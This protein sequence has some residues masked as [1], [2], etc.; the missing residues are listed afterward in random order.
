MVPDLRVVGDAPI[1]DIAGASRSHTFSLDAADP[2]HR[3]R[4]LSTGSG[5]VPGRRA[6]D[7]L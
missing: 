4:S 3:S 5:K 2:Q 1:W 6:N 7:S